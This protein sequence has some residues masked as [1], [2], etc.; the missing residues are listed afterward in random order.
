M[1]NPEAAS[2][3][4]SVIAISVE[5]VPFSLSRV[6]IFGSPEAIENPRRPP[7]AAKQQVPYLGEQ[8]SRV[9]RGCTQ[10][11][12]DA[13]RTQKK[14]DGSDD[15]STTEHVRSRDSVVDPARERENTGRPE[16]RLGEPCP[17]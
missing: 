17:A 12:R 15:V 14:S 11:L 10:K 1:T 3:T 16:G 7:P 9:V 8:S 2:A 6:F 4:G 13:M 5:S